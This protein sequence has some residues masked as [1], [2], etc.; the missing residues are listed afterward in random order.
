MGAVFILVGYLLQEN[1]RQNEIDE[2]VIRNFQKQYVEYEKSI[3][4]EVETT[5][6]LI[7]TKPVLWWKNSA[8]R[9]ALPG[10]CIERRMP[11]DPLR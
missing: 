11:C 2:K 9:R 7:S 6:S 4:E 1:I 3:T 10:P 5:Y 8:P